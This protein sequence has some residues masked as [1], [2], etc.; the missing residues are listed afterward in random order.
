MLR[1][2]HGPVIFVG[3]LLLAASIPALRA[4]G[5]TPFQRLDRNGDGLLQRDELP[6]RLQAR[7]AEID[8]DNDGRITEQ[9][10][11]SFMRAQR[12]PR[13]NPPPD[14]RDVSYGPSPANKLD[15]WKP[16]GPKPAPL[17]VFIHGGGF[18]GGD[19]RSANMALIRR[20]LELGMCAAS[21][22]YRLSGEAPY[23]AAML[24]SARAIQFLRSKA[25][26]WGIDPKR[27]AACGGS[28]GA[29]ISLW[30][31]FHDDL[32][33]PNSQDP[34]ARQSTRLS[35]AIGLAAQTT[36][37]PRQIKQIVPG[38]AYQDVALKL[39]FGLPPTWNWD[40]AQI[41]PELDAKLRDASPI[42]HL[43]ADDPPVFLFYRRDQQRPGNIHHPN[44]GRFLKRAMDKLGIECIV[45]LDTDYPDPRAARE[46]MLAFLCRHLGAAYHPPAR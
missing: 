3:A 27:V 12:R 19:K 4:A 25:D 7:F 8:R 23:P 38:N 42:T 46:D 18:R 37:D 11:R 10:L 33:D 44:F 6:P 41:T 20:A 35:C 31:A 45:R 34:V 28:A 39:F 36:Y 40:T 30:L 26:E 22:N 17:L 5:Q 15:F 32:A 9:E 16:R 2:C 1:R 43:T 29:G 21:I 24:D 14:L 13:L